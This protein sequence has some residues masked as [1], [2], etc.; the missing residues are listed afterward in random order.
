MVQGSNAYW[1]VADQGYDFG[2]TYFANDGLTGVN[3]S[4]DSDW[5]CR[6]AIH[7]TEGRAFIIM[8]DVNSTFYCYPTTGYDERLSQV[9]GIGL[10][11]KANVPTAVDSE[12]NM[13]MADMGYC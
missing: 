3:K 5:Y 4:P 9:V 10:G 13:S 12:P 7:R 1:T 8:V 2:P 11:E 6:A